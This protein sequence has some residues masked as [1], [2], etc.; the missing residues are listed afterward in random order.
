[1]KH[2]DKDEQREFFDELMDAIQKSLKQKNT[3]SLQQVIESWQ[4]TAQVK[5]NPK[6]YAILTRPRAKGKWTPLEDVRAELLG[7]SRR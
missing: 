5:A 7:G 1:V 6:L 4:A 3:E 2:L